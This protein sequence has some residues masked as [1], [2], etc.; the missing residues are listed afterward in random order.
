MELS[1]AATAAAAELIMES[2]NKQNCAV[3]YKGVRLVRSGKYMARV[4]ISGTRR[5]YH[6]GVFVTAE[7]A[8]RAADLGYLASQGRGVETNFPAEQYSDED[9]KAARAKLKEPVKPIK[10]SQY[11]GV[12]CHR[13]GIWRPRIYFYQGKGVHLGVYKDEGQAARQ[14]D[15]A[16]L[17][18]HGCDVSVCK[19]KLNFFTHWSDS[20]PEQLQAET[21]DVGVWITASLLK[22]A[23]PAAVV[24]KEP[25]EMKPPALATFGRKP[26]M[27]SSHH[28]GAA[29][30]LIRA[31]QHAPAAAKHSPLIAAASAAERRAT[32]AGASG[33]GQKSAAAAAAAGT[34]VRAAAGAATA[35]AG[36]GRREGELLLL[37]VM[38][39]AATP[40]GGAAAVDAGRVVGVGAGHKGKQATGAKQHGG[41]IASMETQQSSK[42]CPATEPA[43]AAAEQVQDRAAVV[44]AAKE[45]LRRARVEREAARHLSPQRLKA[46]KKAVKAA[47]AGRKE[48]K[49]AAKA[50]KAEREQAKAAAAKAE[51]KQ[52]KAA[53]AAKAVRKQAKAAA[54]AKAVRKEAKAAAEAEQEEA[55]VAAVDA[56][57]PA[58]AAATNMAAAAAV[59][60]AYPQH[61]NTQQQQHSRKRLREESPA[62]ASIMTYSDM[63]RVSKKM[64]SGMKQQEGKVHTLRAPIGQQQQQWLASSI[65]P[66]LMG[67]QHQQLLHVDQ[68]T[69]TLQTPSSSSLGSSKRKQR[70]H[71]VD[72]QQ[73]PTAGKKQKLHNKPSSA[74]CATAPHHHTL[75]RELSAA[76]A[77]VPAP[78]GAPACGRKLPAAG[79]SRP[80]AA[81]MKI[82]ATKGCKK[83]SRARAASTAA[84]AGVHPGRAAASGGRPVP[85][86]QQQ[87]QQEQWTL[88]ERIGNL[89]GMLYGGQ[90][91]QKSAAKLRK[92]AY[93]TS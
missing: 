90:A 80:A 62:A 56:R 78:A 75:C 7:E 41:E 8:A 93:T 91:R 11:K 42:G 43:I 1:G 61:F 49:A 35:T 4:L 19:H 3:K 77:A 24:Q 15:L 25:G 89:Q 18:V 59:Q 26:T 5:H 52:A 50:A 40:V 29:A 71:E 20:T 45:E 60:A 39:A 6:L 79:A 55:E 33:R 85:K 9:I 92:G 17:F 68:K 14:Y 23:R 72:L 81:G 34:A 27:L 76:A 87:Q 88:L 51:R 57:Q 83:G 36:A 44:A 86:Q 47:K 70:L 63:P 16:Q 38:S 31:E 28:A 30:G 46:A 84:K 64:K 53:A 37:Q 54:A 2:A 67:T 48:A 10:S 13:P 69:A 82:A 66:S 65:K 22:Q 74:P 12:E 73:L 21:R 58:K 32:T